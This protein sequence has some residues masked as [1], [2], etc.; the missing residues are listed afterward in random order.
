MAFCICR[1]FQEH[2]T[3]SSRI[4][5]ASRFRLS[6][7][8]KSG[9]KVFTWLLWRQ[10]AVVGALLCPETLDSLTRFDHDL[11]IILLAFLK[12]FSTLMTSK[13]MHFIFLTCQMR[14]TN[15]LTKKETD[16]HSLFNR[17]YHYCNNVSWQVL[18]YLFMKVLI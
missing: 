1:L 7:S 10:L 6:G 13:C 5:W 8:V 9:K 14:K 2:L 4:K 17:I 16:C 3:H 12:S 18:T 11:V 15:K